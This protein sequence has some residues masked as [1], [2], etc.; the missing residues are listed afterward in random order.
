MLPAALLWLVLSTTALVYIQRGFLYYVHRFLRLVLKKEQP[1]LI[2]FSLL[3][4]PGILLHEGSH[5]LMAKVLGVSTN[6]ISLIPR[7]VGPRNLKLGYVK[8][9]STT[10]LRR[11]TIGAAPLIVGLVC[12]VSICFGIFNLDYVI[13]ALLQ[14]DYM[15]VQKHLEQAIQVPEIG[16][17]V[18]LLITIS[19]LILPSRSDREYWLPAGLVLLLFLGVFLIIV[20]ILS[21]REPVL[22][23]L[24]AMLNAVSAS[25]SLTVILDMVLLLPL[26]VVVRMGRKLAGLGIR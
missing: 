26:V 22:A 8:I 18:Y 15:L 21:V 5:W 16:M 6:G 9:G 12:I 2:A 14:R 20:E 3:F 19:N 17:W 13:T 7:W 11:A 10:V 25:F 24:V 1:T 4:F 23:Y